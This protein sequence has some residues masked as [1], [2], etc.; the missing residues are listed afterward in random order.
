MWEV[1]LALSAALGVGLVKDPDLR[2]ENF[3]EL[4]NLTPF[5]AQ[6]LEGV[7]DVAKLDCRLVECEPINIFMYILFHRSLHD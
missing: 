6:F 7:Q 3:Q 4:F 1:G 2:L 5:G